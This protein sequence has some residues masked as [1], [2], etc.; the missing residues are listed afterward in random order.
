VRVVGSIHSEVP[1]KPV[2]P[3]EPTGSS[4]PRL[5]ENGESMSQPK[6]RRLDDVGGCWGV[7]IFSTR[8]EGR[9][10]PPVSK[11]RANF[12][13]SS[14]VEN[15]PACPATPPMRRAVGSCTTPR[16]MVLFSSY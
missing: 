1:V 3:N 10:E 7:L 5:V 8:S 4:S 15:S 12:A 2:C 14:A 9:T 13:R 11:A 16:S 6:P